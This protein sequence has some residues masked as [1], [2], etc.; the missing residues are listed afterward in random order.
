ME[1]FVV[2]DGQPVLIDRF[3]EDA[4]EVDVGGF[5]RARLCHYGIMEHIEEAEFIPVTRLARIP[6]FS[7]TQP[8][9]EQIRRSNKEARVGSRGDR[10]DEYSIC[11]QT[12]R[13][14]GSALC[15]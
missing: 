10:A 11:G 9:L 15:A 8:V 6:P 1:A 3:L 5:R 2:A 12:H 14:R 13:N 4:T 7:L